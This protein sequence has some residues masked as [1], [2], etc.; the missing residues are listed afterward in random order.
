L[1]RRRLFFIIISLFTGT[2]LYA[3][4]T[5]SD[6][7]AT[8]IVQ[9][10]GPQKTILYQ[11][12]LLQQHAS[13]PQSEA[14]FQQHKANLPAMGPALRNTVAEE[15]LAHTHL[16]YSPEKASPIRLWLQ[17]QTFTRWMLYLA[18]ILATMALLRILYIYGDPIRAF[19]IRQFESVFRLLFT[20]F[21]LTIEL[22]VIGAGGIAAGVYL[23]DMALQIIVLHTGIFLI[24]TQ[25][26][27]L[28]TKEYMA[29]DYSKYVVNTLKENN[30][31]KIFSTIFIPAIIS[32]AALLFVIYRLPADE[33]YYWEAV[34][35]GLVAVYTLPFV[36]RLEYRFSRVLL[37]FYEN[38]NYRSK[39]GPLAH[40]TVFTF[41]ISIPAAAFL[42]AWLHPCISCLYLLVI[43][44]LLILSIVNNDN[45]NRLQFIYLQL[46]TLAYIVYVLWKGRQLGSEIMI[47][48]AIISINVLVVITYWQ[49]PVICWEMNWRRNKIW[50]GMLGMGALLWLLAQG[51]QFFL[52]HYLLI[53]KY[54]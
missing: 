18:A 45:N 22:L 46:I 21:L 11:Y 25:C 52:H 35:V 50:W 3:G 26:T 31:S 44:L 14:F 36:K 9:L 32:L 8:V 40:Y 17:T 53:V 54:K 39:A 47:W 24:W 4:T 16:L 41:L 30:I 20:P 7:V 19:L 13:T 2:S 38:R 1:I 37:P 29:V 49:I 6:S 10:S 15:L 23:T 42:P 34:I 28:L 33:W 43:M 27:A 5:Q 12:A 48:Q 51:T